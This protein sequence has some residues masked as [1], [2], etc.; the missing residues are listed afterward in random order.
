MNIMKTEFAFLNSTPDVP[1]VTAQSKIFLYVQQH[2]HVMAHQKGTIT[3]ELYKCIR[4]NKQST[5]LTS[6]KIFT[7]GEGDGLGRLMSG[8]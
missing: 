1:S 4:H 6:Y 5:H 3:S 7:D 2:Q 8:I